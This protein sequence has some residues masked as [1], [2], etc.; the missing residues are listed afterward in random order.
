MSRREFEA[1]LKAKREEGQLDSSG[2][3]T[4]DFIRAREKLANYQL[5]RPGYYLQK[6]LQGLVG[7]H[8]AAINVRLGRHDLLVE[9]H[10]IAPDFL[11]TLQPALANPLAASGCWRDLATGLA[12]AFAAQIEGIEILG[13]NQLL[14]LGQ[15]NTLSQVNKSEAFYIRLVRQRP[16]ALWQRLFGAGERAAEH[17]MLTTGFA[18]VAIPIWLDGKRLEV[19]TLGAPR[20]PASSYPSADFHLVERF[21]YSSDLDATAAIQAPDPRARRP[22]HLVTET[23]F[24]PKRTEI[25]LTLRDGANT[26]LLR[27]T[28]EG[29]FCRAMLAIRYDLL[30]EA[31]IAFVKRGLLIEV[32]R[33]D[34]GCPGVTGVCASDGLTTDASGY[35][36]VRNRAFQERMEWLKEQVLEMV[37]DFETVRWRAFYVTDSGPHRHLERLPLRRF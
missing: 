19:P 6:I 30:G 21:I 25:H 29:Q 3:F 14:R 26:V 18:Y 8:T 1:L 37:S 20:G 5:E 13:H 10:P 4:L 2:A 36:L 23:D 7:L 15:T 34:L 12:S 16:A 11:A 27:K 24:C 28:G 32:A 17:R 31:T 35:G 9:A 33:L 22:M